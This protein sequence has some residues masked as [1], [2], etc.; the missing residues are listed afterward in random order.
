MNTEWRIFARR[1]GRSFAAR[2]RLIVTS[3]G[4]RFFD[5]SGVRCGATASRCAAHSFVLS[6]GKISS[7]SS[8]SS[9]PSVCPT[10]E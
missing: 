4:G 2:W 9:A 7:R 8:H 3:G 5:C 10:S 1:S 6:S